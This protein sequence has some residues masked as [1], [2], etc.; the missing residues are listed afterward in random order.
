MPI[1]TPAD[2][3][4]TEFATLAN[5]VL[6]QIGILHTRGISQKAAALRLRSDV[7]QALQVFVDRVMEHVDLCVAVTEIERAPPP[8]PRVKRRRQTERI[9]RRK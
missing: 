2:D 6:M 9:K 3:A 4:L 5:S 7:R 8:A 1:P